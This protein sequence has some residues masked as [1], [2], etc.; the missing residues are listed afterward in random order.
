MKRRKSFLP[1]VLLLLAVLL[2]SPVAVRADPGEIRIPVWQSNAYTID[3]SDTVV[4]YSGWAACSPGLVRVYTMASNFEVRLDG[5]TR[6][7]S[8]ITSRRM[9][10]RTRCAAALEPRPPAPAM[11]MHTD[12]SRRI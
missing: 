12:P 9:P 3:V 8:A 6:S 4:L 11:P 5:A 10:E 7:K 2:V 1:L